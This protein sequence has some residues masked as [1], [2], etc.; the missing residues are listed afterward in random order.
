M[1][2]VRITSAGARSTPARMCSRSR[3]RPSAPGRRAAS[4][5]TMTETGTAEAAGLARRAICVPL[6]RVRLLQLTFGPLRRI[7]GLHAFEGLGVHVD[8]DVLDESLGRLPARRPRVP[9]PAAGLRRFLELDDLRVWFAQRVL[10][11]VGRRTHDVA[12]LGCHP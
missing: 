10:L 8:E 12:V 2:S 3:S 11:P 6:L 5:A 4:T 1:N 9:G 7:L